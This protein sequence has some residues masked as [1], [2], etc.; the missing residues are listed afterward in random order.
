M[1]DLR[2]VIIGA[3]ALG[4]FTAAELVDSRR[5]NVS[6][7]DAG[8]PGGGSSGRSVGMVETQYLTTPDIEVRA[9][10][11]RAYERLERDHGLGFV[12]GGYLR[13]GHTRADLAKF[14]ASV[15]AQRHHG[16]RD[17]EVLTPGEIRRRWPRIV[18]EDLTAGLYGAWDGYVDGHEMCQLLVSHVRR[19][20]GRVL[21]QTAL[22]GAVQGANS[23]H[24][25][26]TNGALEADVVVN[27]AGAHAGVVGA[28]LGAPV[29][30]LP[31]LH[32]AL[33]VNLDG[34]E[35]SPFVMDYVPGS[36]SDGVYFR[37][38]RNDQLIAGLHTDEVLTPPVSPD[39]PLGSAGRD[40]V[41]RVI[42]LLAAR[43]AGAERFTVGRSWTGIYPMTPDRQPVVGTHEEVESV[44]CALGAGGSGIQLAPA[45]GAMAAD[46]VLQRASEFHYG[47]RWTHG[48][49]RAAFQVS[50]RP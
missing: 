1:T 38:E 35:V 16:V 4:L 25:A 14:E 36:G 2:V 26:T 40:F 27:A 41:E 24:L 31:Q 11:R 28:M 13:L 9:F 10:G 39:L 44:V 49:R 8:Q 43:L 32:G 30:L 6:V 21:G 17:S 5:A 12:H 33:V 48:S 46:A 29:D 23:W 18:T 42:E 22:V 15:A 47:A 45:I 19:G 37:S 20:G 7:I 50:Q 34:P 3:G